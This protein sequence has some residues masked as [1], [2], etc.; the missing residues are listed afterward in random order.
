MKGKNNSEMKTQ[1]KGTQDQINTTAHALQ[2][3]KGEKIKNYI[4]QS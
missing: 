4:H 3:I 1:L 2:D